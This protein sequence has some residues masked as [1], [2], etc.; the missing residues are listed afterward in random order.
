M[1]ILTFKISSA[2]TN[3]PYTPAF[4]G[5]FNS[6]NRPEHTESAFRSS[7]SQTKKVDTPEAAPPYVRTEPHHIQTLVSSSLVPKNVCLL[8]KPSQ[9]PSPGAYELAKLQEINI[10]AVPIDSILRISGYCGLP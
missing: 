2:H 7:Y 9:K 1:P 4:A 3:R 10:F 5:V 6:L 8:A